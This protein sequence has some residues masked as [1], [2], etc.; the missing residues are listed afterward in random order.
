MKGIFIDLNYLRFQTNYL[1]L[2]FR[3][4]NFATQFIE[5]ALVDV[6]SWDKEKSQELKQKEITARRK[7]KTEIEGIHYYFKKAIDT[8][9]VP[10]RTISLS[11]RHS[12][13]STSS[14]KPIDLSIEE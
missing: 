12:L 5:C 9:K 4:A 6:N 8:A 14:T 11:N 10:R 2:S 3:L 1:Y 7:F 13:T